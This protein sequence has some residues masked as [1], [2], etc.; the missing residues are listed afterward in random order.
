VQTVGTWAG[1]RITRDRGGLGLTLNG[2]NLGH[3]DW[4]GRLVLPF[5]PE[6]RDE[7]VAKKISHH[8]VDHPENG[9]SIFDIQNAPDVDRALL[10]LRFAYLIADTKQSSDAIVA[11]QGP[12]I[13]L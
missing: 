9:R 4:D 12:S 6:I 1:A 7:L 11:A 13:Q 8:V 10:L 3:L 2:A 5:K